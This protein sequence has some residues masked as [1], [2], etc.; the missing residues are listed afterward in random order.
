MS[1]YLVISRLS[2]LREGQFGKFS[3]NYQAA[4]VYQLKDGTEKRGIRLFHDTVMMLCPSRLPPHG[5]AKGE[6]GE[7]EVVKRKTNVC[8]HWR[9]AVR[10]KNITCPVV[11]KE[12][13]NNEYI[14][15]E[16][17]H[18][19][20]PEACPALSTKVSS[21]V[22]RKATEDVFRPAADII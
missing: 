19:H 22:K 9:C 3:Y 20:P 15:G 13:N 7:D 12:H 10:N 14:R 5:G 4:A 11:I 18:C 8:V 6:G 1:F 2:S 16:M 17:D 21:I